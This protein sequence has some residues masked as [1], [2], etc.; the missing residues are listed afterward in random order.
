MLDNF[1]QKKEILE[2]IKLVSVY[3]KNFYEP[4]KNEFK[5]FE[6]MYYELKTITFIAMAFNCIIDG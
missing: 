5:K 4:K 1:I 6:S 2:E 3:K